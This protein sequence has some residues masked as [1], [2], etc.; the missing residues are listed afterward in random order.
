MF[1]EAS[2]KCDASCPVLHALSNIRVTLIDVAWRAG[3]AQHGIATVLSAQ[4]LTSPAP[5]ICLLVLCM[6]QWQALHCVS[7]LSLRAALGVPLQKKQ[8]QGTRADKTTGHGGNVR[9]GGLIYAIA[10]RVYYL[11]PCP[12]TKGKLAY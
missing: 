3:R 10:L 8:R 7:P 2:L 6:M 12:I 9:P 1:R 11:L 4:W 5:R